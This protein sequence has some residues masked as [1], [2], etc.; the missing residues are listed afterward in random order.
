MNM[1]KKAILS[2]ATL[3]TLPSVANKFTGSMKGIGWGRTATTIGAASFAGAMSSDENQ[4]FGSFAV[5][6]GIGALAGAGLSHGL[7]AALKH[8]SL[9]YG[10]RAWR[11]GPTVVSNVITP[12]LG[13]VAKV[14][15]QSPHP[16]KTLYKA[17]GGHWDPKMVDS[18]SKAYMFGSRLN[19][20]GGRNMLF[21][22]GAMLSGG[23]FNASLITGNQRNHSTN[24][25]QSGNRMR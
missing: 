14:F 13:G 15:P 5:G 19:S 21:T 1:L 25:S 9:A 11:K 10:R 24:R 6:A 16:N 12:N 3:D 18:M 22:S 23:L 7:P 20:S 8:G 17:R 4:S 2:S